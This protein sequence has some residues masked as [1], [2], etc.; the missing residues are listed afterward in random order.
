MYHLVK[1]KKYITANH[2][3]ILKLKVIPLLSG[4]SHPLLPAVE[5]QVAVVEVAG[6]VEAQAAVAE[7]AAGDKS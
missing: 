3:I 5:V 1:G 4:C 7:A 2:A 6:A